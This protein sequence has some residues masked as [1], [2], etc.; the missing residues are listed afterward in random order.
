M[1]KKPVNIHLCMFHSASILCLPKEPE[2]VCV[3]VHLAQALP[4]LS[5]ATSGRIRASVLS[6]RSSSPSCSTTEAVLKL[7]KK[8]A[9]SLLA[10]S[11]SS[12]P[13]TALIN[14]CVPYCARKLQEA[15]GGEGRGEQMVARLV[16][17]Q[18]GAECLGVFDRTD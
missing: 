7:G 3:F 14:V 4:L 6:T 9:S 16:L 17:S 13:C 8:K 10:W 12:L 15:R 1:T 18:R 11:L 5:L 2:Q